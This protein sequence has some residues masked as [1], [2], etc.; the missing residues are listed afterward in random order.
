M[1]NFPVTSE[2]H[3]TESFRNSK[4]L[5]VDLGYPKDTPIYS[6]QDGIVKKTVDYGDENIGKGVFV[7]WENGYTAI[8]GHLNEISVQKGDIINK[9]ELLGLSGNTGNVFGENGG[10]HL[11][12]GLKNTDGQFI[13]PE[14]YVNLLQA[15]S[16]V[17]EL[18]ENFNKLDP[19]D[20]LH[21]ALDEL[22]NL[23]LNFINMLSQL[24]YDHKALST[25]HTIFSYL[26]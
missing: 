24:P 9:G 19:Y 20:I 26:F 12:F 6:I 18:Q 25:L 5:G 3:A 14:P 8:Y 7:E 22:S 11:H 4:H 1:S 2:F 16:S 21:Q 15:N 23:P 17:T 10:Y 13:N